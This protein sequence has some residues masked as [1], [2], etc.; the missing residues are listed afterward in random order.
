[1]TF[2][3]GYQGGWEGF[4]T[5]QVDDIAF[6][7][8][9]EFKEVGDVPEVGHSSHEETQGASTF[10]IDFLA[11][12]EGRRTPV[13]IEHNLRSGFVT[14]EVRGKLVKNWQVKSF[15]EAFAAAYNFTVDNH[16]FTLRKHVNDEGEETDL[17]VLDIDMIPF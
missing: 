6:D 1:M 9:E 14:L 10:R 8:L 13:A 3:L 16:K 11:F 5:L 15:Y 7:E 2:T 4:Y 12:L 17:L